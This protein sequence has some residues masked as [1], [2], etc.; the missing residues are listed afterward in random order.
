LFIIFINVLGSPMSSNKG[1]VAAN[2]PMSEDQVLLAET[3]DL[4]KTSA[5]RHRLDRAACRGHP[6]L[7][8]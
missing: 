7:A 5:E 4:L 3:R 2:P 6:P 8:G 1:D